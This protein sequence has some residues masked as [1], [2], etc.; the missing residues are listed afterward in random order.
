MQITKKAFTLVELIVVVVILAILSTIWFLSLKSYSE[1]T[2]DSTRATDI[3]NIRT[4]LELYA[5]KNSIYPSPTDSVPITHSWSVIW[6][7]WTYWTG[8]LFKTSV[9]NKVPR[10]PLFDVEYVYSLT[11]NKLEYQIWAVMERPNDIK[12]IINTSEAA[13]SL[14]KNTA[15]VRW[16]YN[17]YVVKSES[18]IKE[19]CYVLTLPS[20]ITEET[21]TWTEYKDIV[22]NN[23]LILDWYSTL[24]KWFQ[25]DNYAPL[26]WFFTLT[27]DEFILYE[28]SDSCK[29]LAEDEVKRIDLVDK[30]QKVY[31]ETW[32][33]NDNSYKDT[34]WLTVVP[35]VSYNSRIVKI[36]AWTMTS[37]ILGRRIWVTWSDD[38]LMCVFNDNYIR[39]WDIVTT[40]L[41]D[42][43]EETE[44]Y[45]CRDISEERL[46]S[47]WVL[48]WSLEHE[49]S[50]C[51]KWSLDACWSSANYSHNTHIYNLP[52][53]EHSE[54]LN[55][56][57][58]TEK[59]YITSQ[60]VNESNWKYFY[61]LTN[62]QC[63]DWKYI[64][65]E[66]NRYLLS[67]D[68]WFFS[69]WENCQQGWD[70]DIIVDEI[71]NCPNCD[72]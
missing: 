42:Y 17:S 15:Y 66:E 48:S 60:V 33:V 12:K 50:T 23:K 39:D 38:I 46:C 14:S 63:N 19:K 25:T 56:K 21:S 32:L 69:D 51:V 53:M 20:I 36:F 58:A 67:C 43:I 28:D 8:S 62:L 27:E 57:D 70:I 61:Y 44:S 40:Y 68:I 35:W 37:A 31:K 2:R 30:I 71:I 22:E 18:E 4:S 34:L 45:E 13:S 41:E 52:R 72:S 10:D 55:I 65:F 11:A 7:Q 16:N 6:N 54:R 49:Y 59:D 1:R 26:K 47:L 5:I 3:H 64:N 29:W 24:P 9:L